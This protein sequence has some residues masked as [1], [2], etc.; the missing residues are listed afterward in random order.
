MDDARRYLVSRDA[1][2][3]IEDSGRLSNP[4]NVEEEIGRYVFGE[5]DVAH[6][7]RVLDNGG[8]TTELPGRNGQHVLS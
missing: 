5:I 1:L 4:E 6:Y 8:A 3:K 7:E 2:T